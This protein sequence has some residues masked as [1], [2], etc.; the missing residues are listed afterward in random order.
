[1][2]YSSI[3]DG[4]QIWH[5]DGRGERPKHLT[6]RESYRATYQGPYTKGKRTAWDG[7]VS[8][9]P[10][11]IINDPVRGFDL[12]MR[13]GEAQAGS[14]TTR[15]IASAPHGYDYRPHYADWKKDPA[16]HPN[17]LLPGRAALFRNVRFEALKLG[18]DLRGTGGCI[19]QDWVGLEFETMRIYGNK[20]RSAYS[21]GGLTFVPKD[22]MFPPIARF[23][24]RFQ[25]KID[26]FST[27]RP[28][29]AP[30]YALL[31][32]GGGYLVSRML[33]I[34][35]DVPHEIAIHWS[36]DAQTISFWLDEI[37][38]L[39]AQQGSWALPAGLKT[40]G[41][42]QFYECGFHIDCWQDNGTGNTD[43][44]GAAGHPDKDQVYTIESLSILEVE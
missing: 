38:V 36:R 11:M 20:A 12:T 42:I 3:K 16:A 41:R 27:P 13:A 32:R 1:M 33:H 40:G 28:G 10:G 18:D 31:F 37:N 35:P 17:L 2:L 23:L 5:A 29:V 7:L 4:T 21:G 24:S 8:N 22:S 25:P 39:K 15:D 30:L 19:I 9:H 14:Y 6:Y 26:P 43:V 44:Q 34:D